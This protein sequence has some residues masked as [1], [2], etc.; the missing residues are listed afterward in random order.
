MANDKLT[1]G[2]LLKAMAVKCKMNL[3]NPEIKEILDNADIS[4]YEIQKELADAFSGS[5][6]SIEDAKN[7]HPEIGKVYKA[8]VFD[9]LDKRLNNA[10]E[11]LELDDA[12]KQ[13]FLAERSSYDR[14]DLIAEAI[15]ALRNKKLDT[16]SSEDKKLLQ[17]Q[18]DKLNAELRDLK[19]QEIE[20]EI[21]FNSQRQKDLTNFVLRN[22]LSG[23]KTI[24]DESTDK[25]KYD[26]CNSA[27]RELLN[28]YQA[29]L[30][31][32]ANGELVLASTNGTDKVYNSKTNTVVTPDELIKNALVRNKILKVTET[33]TGEPNSTGG[34]ITDRKPAGAD[35]RQSEQMEYVKAKNAKLLQMF[36]ETGK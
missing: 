14:V 9:Q 27:I 10:L 6:I 8:Q 31:T 2:Q 4:G 35:A 24:L 30:I 16:N 7:G 22:K 32:D 33:P 23:Y 13:R 11:A 21:E 1:L 20:K 18:V 19:K 17:V 5:L 25:I 28:E 29:E 12:G 36:G 15:K 3:E 34:V 26:S